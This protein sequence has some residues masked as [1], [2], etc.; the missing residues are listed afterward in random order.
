[1]LQKLTSKLSPGLLIDLDHPTDNPQLWT[2]VLLQARPALLGDEYRMSFSALNRAAY[3]EIHGASLMNPIELF[4][5][6]TKQTLQQVAL[7]DRRA[8]S[9]V[10]Q[11][12][13][14]NVVKRRSALEREL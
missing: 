3:T 5:A 2:Q 10:G 7:E 12:Y 8:L 4:A 11:R 6:E 1:M 13:V 9:A 14:F